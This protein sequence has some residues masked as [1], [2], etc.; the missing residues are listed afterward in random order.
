MMKGYFFIAVRRLTRQW[1]FS[2]I[3]ITGLATGIAAAILILHYVHFERSYDT[4]NSGYNDIYRLR[5]E[6]TSESGEAVRFA[7]CA[8]PAGL[9]IRA[10]FPEVD[11]VA[12]I[13]RFKGTVS[14]ENIKYYEE[15]IFFAEPQFL[16]MF[17]FRIVT[18]AKPDKLGEQGNMFITRNTAIKYFGSDNPLGR[19]LELDGRMVFRVAGILENVPANSHIKFDFLLSWPDVQVMYSPAFEQSW[20]QTGVFTYLSFVPGVDITTFNRKLSDLVETEFGEALDYYK[21]T[22]DLPLQPLSEI[23]LDSNYM[24]E[25]EVNGDKTRVTALFIVALFLIMIAWVNYIVLSTAQSGSRVPETGMRKIAGA[26]RSQVIS[27]LLVETIILN[28]ISLLL[29]IAAIIFLSPIFGQITGI[30]VN[31]ILGEPYIISWLAVIF[32]GGLLIAGIYPVIVHSSTVPSMALKG[33]QSTSRT[34]L[35]VRKVLVV[36][37]NFISLVIITGT[38]IIYLQETFLRKADTGISLENL[39][40]VKAPRIRT[41]S[42]PTTLNSFIEQ[43]KR[44]NGVSETATATEVPGRQ[45]Y[46]DA[47]GIF[48]TGSDQSKNYQIIGVDYNYINVFGIDIIAGRNFSKEFPS[49]SSALILNKK[50]VSWMGFDSPEEAIGKE[51]NYWGEIF[52]IIGVTGDFHQ[53]SPRFE[54]EPTLLRFLPQG[55]N[56]MGNVVIKISGNDYED[57]MSRI[58]VL[59]DDYFP[60]NSFDYFRAD[61]YYSEQFR[62]DK[63]LGTVFTIFSIITIIITVLGVVGLAAYLID[64]QK[65]DISIRKVLGD[66]PAGII[67]LFSRTFLELIIIAS[68]FS[69]P[70]SWIILSR[71][72]AGFATHIRPSLIMFIIP[73]LFTLFYTGLTVFM[74]VLKESNTNPVRNLRYE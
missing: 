69:I 4:F 56:L 72:L 6:R 41:G 21:V 74:I 53:Q 60:G 15:R 48:R 2:I 40:A 51:V 27:Q 5:L 3:N 12:R 61:D 62:Q 22:M 1:L 44:I 19:S 37:Q 70:V 13:L 33:K 47:G 64:Q 25:Y 68:L 10:L 30:P 65:K 57:I 55:Q 8:P 29:A 26:S 59:Y 52:H 46:W 45:L 31:G 35:L 67:V 71:W 43:V 39:I 34:N 16:E 49:D 73:L 58:R 42:Y 28:A 66:S 17:D 7:S 20:G 32:L 24:Q 11:K 9:R 54:V 38:L 36:V 18:G 14:N 23:H 63:I 50:A